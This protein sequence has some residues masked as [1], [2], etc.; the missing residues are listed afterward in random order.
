MTSDTGEPLARSS[1][2]PLSAATS[3]DA[4]P[5]RPAAVRFDESFLH[6]SNGWLKDEEIQR[7]TMT[8][9]F[10]EQ[11][12]AEWFAGLPSRSDY[13]IWGIELDG[14]PIGAFGIKHIRNG[15]GEFWGYIGDKS[16]WGRGIGGW[17]IDQ[18]FNYAKQNDIKTIYLHVAIDNERA[19]SL[20][21][22]HGFIGDDS[23][24]D[25]LRMSRRV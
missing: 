4:S 17:M 8:P 3:S 19:R 18:A 23:G 9:S 24:S 11:Q 21:S 25:V 7:L 16:N 20:Y 5:L 15:S 6:A 1:K 12:Q 14:A 2:T 13:V 10:T 22:R